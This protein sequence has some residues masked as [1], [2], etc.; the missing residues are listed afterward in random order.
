M[1]RDI[2]LLSGKR[3]G[4]LLAVF[5]CLF[6]TGD[7]GRV[8]GQAPGQ[9]QAPI[10]PKQF[11]P[12]ITP[13]L[14]PEKN[15]Y[16]EYIVYI[17]ARLQPQ[18]LNYKDNSLKPMC[19]VRVTTKKRDYRNGGWEERK[20][21]ENLWYGNG[22]PV[23]CRRFQR[24]PIRQQGGV[25]VIVE[26]TKD[27]PECTKAI[28]NALVRVLLDIHVANGIFERAYIQRDLC[29]KLTSDL[30]VMKFYPVQIL[31]TRRTG[32]LLH[33]VSQ[34]AGFDTYYFFYTN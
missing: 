31:S 19:E 14:I 21:Y 6:M 1:R 11:F 12:E 16:S 25:V 2:Q 24:M 3:F 27:A 17:N 22:V 26:P 32:A 10:N 20:D 4:V 13:E 18:F 9:A 28:A 29:E 7:G 5:L 33:V 30:G 34:P 23:G 15:L 8:L